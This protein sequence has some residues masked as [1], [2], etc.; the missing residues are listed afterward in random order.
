MKVQ[1]RKEGFRSN[2]PKES[3]DNRTP[4]TWHSLPLWSWGRAKG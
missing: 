3:W 1:W 4:S 2:C